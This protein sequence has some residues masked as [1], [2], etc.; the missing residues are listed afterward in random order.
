MYPIYLKPSEEDR[1]ALFRN[2]AK[3]IRRDVTSTEQVR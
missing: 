1:Y 3:L 2:N